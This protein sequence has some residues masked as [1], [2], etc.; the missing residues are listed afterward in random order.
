MFAFYFSEPVHDFIKF[1]RQDSNEGTWGAEK[2]SGGIENTNSNWPG[3]QGRPA[4]IIPAPKFTIYF[5]TNGTVNGWGYKMKITPYYPTD[6][7]DDMTH[8]SSQI[9]SDVSQ[10][11]RICASSLSS[12][13]LFI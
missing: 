5:K 10:C 12:V 13:L 1:Y 3:F 8:R 9:L 6:D 11:M 4:L 7:T 2:Y